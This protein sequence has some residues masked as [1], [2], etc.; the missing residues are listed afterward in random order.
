MRF[1]D[2]FLLITRD[3]SIA[4]GITRALECGIKDYN[5]TV[6]KDKGGANFKLDGNGG[7]VLDK[8]GMM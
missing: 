8:D 4:M 1:V 5:C 3:K 2:D 7:V 6:N